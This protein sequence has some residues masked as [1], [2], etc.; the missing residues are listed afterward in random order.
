MTEMNTLFE[1]AQEI[2]V[3]ETRFSL[4]KL[5]PR[6]LLELGVLNLLETGDQSGD[7]IIRELSPLTRRAYGFGVNYPLIHS[8]E[9][10]GVL[11]GYDREGK[12]PR[13]YTLTCKGQSRLQQLRTQYN[14]SETEV[15]QVISFRREVISTQNLA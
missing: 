2:A 1:L 15:N 8:L 11:R 14:L 4:P 6:Q 7:V 13:A 9:D 12:L 3:S 5:L 10:E